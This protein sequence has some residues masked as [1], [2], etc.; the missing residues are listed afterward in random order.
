LDGGSHLNE[1]QDRYANDNDCYF[2]IWYSNTSFAYGLSSRFTIHKISK[3]F[4]MAGENM[5]ICII[6]EGSYPYVTGGVSSWTQMLISWMSEYQFIIYAIGAKAKDRGKFCYQMPDNV[7]GLKEIFMDEAFDHKAKWGK[8][9]GMKKHEKEALE[10]LLVG[11]NPNWED[12]FSLF[13]E[14]RLHSIEEFLTSKD[15]F[16]ILEVVYKKKYWKTPFADFYW[17][18]RSMVCPLL[19]IIKQG[20]PEADIY[21]SVSAGYSGILGSLGKSIYKKPFIMTEH[22]IYTR[23]REEEIIKSDWIKSCFKDIWIEYFHS[24]SKCAYDHADKVITLFNSNKEI[25]IE[26]GCN[27]NK[28]E[29][30][31]NGIQLDTYSGLLHESIE[32]DYINV[33]AVVR[34]VPIK[35]IK[36]MIKGFS[37]A[38][39][40]YE[41]IRFYVM[42]PLEEDMQY[43][44]ECEQ[45]VENLA[46]KDII[47]TGKVNIADYIGKMDILVLSSISEGQP[48]AIL[49]GMASS[50]PFIATDVGSCRDLLYGNGDNYGEAGLIVPVMES[51]KIGQAIVQLC[52]DKELR[53][54]MGR[55]AFKRVAEFYSKE[56]LV[57]AYKEVYSSYGG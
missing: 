14:N 47:F 3:S 46:L 39:K 4:I 1:V 48:L 28:I 51:E 31:P 9:L 36:T 24:I 43:Y 30:I 21:H 49:E 55:S 26:L 11:E 8:R 38:K 40:K 41:K 56:R 23:E 44:K 18:F 32:E 19:F 27:E 17:T 50:K 20:V 53:T 52:K 45:L 13:K 16:D 34:V 6:A 25:Q 2:D 57:T 37:I 15:F 42:G 54:S 12:L 22:G 33:G 29:I 7:I 5:K 10:N 35:D